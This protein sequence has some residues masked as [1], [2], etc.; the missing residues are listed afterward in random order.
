M[1]QSL[2]DLV[3]SA[4]AHLNL[5]DMKAM[6]GILENLVFLSRTRN[7]LYITDTTDMIPSHKFEHL[8]CFFP[9]MLALGA[10]TLPEAV[11]SAKERELHMWAVR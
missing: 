2:V 6:Q 9:G 1:V 3:S 4:I 7:L 11:M 10:T 5:L 8:S